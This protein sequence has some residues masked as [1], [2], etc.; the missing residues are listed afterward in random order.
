MKSPVVDIEM[1]KR[2]YA[3]NF[4]LYQFM[5]LEV[6]EAG[7]LKYRCGVPL[8][9][10]NMNHFGTIHAAVQ[11][12]LAE[13]LG[14]MFLWANFGFDRYLGVVANM[15]IRFRRPACTAVTSEACITEKELHRVQEELQ[16]LCKT[17]YTLTID[18]R[19]MSDELI[20]TAS[21]VYHARD[22]R[23][24]HGLPERIKPI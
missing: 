13:T 8:N 5:G 15:N 23:L 18:V 24:F 12:A 17:V 4:P 9:E 21:A 6:L 14:G 10:K 20:A 7:P 16:T 2:H 22:S 11:W 19:D 1:V 3:L